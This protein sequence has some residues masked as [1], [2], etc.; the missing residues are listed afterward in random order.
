MDDPDHSA[1]TF[2][3]DKS[4]NEVSWLRRPFGVATT[5]LSGRRDRRARGF[6]PPGEAEIAS[7][8]GEGRMRRV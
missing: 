1:V 8:F 6:Q 4:V 2:P 7:L 3:D 5:G